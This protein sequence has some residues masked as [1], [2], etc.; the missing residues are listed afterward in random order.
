MK[1]RVAVAVLVGV[2]CL[3]LPAFADGTFSSRRTSESEVSKYRRG[4]YTVYG[5]R[6]APH[7]LSAYAGRR[8]STGSV[9]D[10][11]SVH[12]SGRALGES[13]GFSHVPG[14]RSWGEG[15]Y[16]S[17]ADITKRRHFSSSGHGWH[18]S[19][20]R[21]RR[22]HPSYDYF[23]FGYYGTPQYSYSAPC[24]H[25]SY[26]YGSYGRPMG[27]SFRPTCP[28]GFRPYC[29]SYARSGIYLHFGW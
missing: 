9:T 17:S 1:A 29:G 7:S 2:L 10:A 5:H 22:R 19:T 14:L 8:I 4:A 16:R 27:H 6:F 20:W 21:R 23:C 24:Y 26:P 13:E 18:G 3:G 11:P 15:E 28:L 12:A 25:H